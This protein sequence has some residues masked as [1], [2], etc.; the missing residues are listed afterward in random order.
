MPRRVPAPTDQELA[1]AASSLARRAGLDAVAD[2]LASAA[3]PSTWLRV[4][5]GRGSAHS[6]V[7]PDYLEGTFL[8]SRPFY[9][10]VDWWEL[11]R[12]L[13]RVYGRKS[14]PARGIPIRGGGFAHPDERR[15]GAS[16]GAN[17][18]GVLAWGHV[19][20]RLRPPLYLLTLS[21]G[22]GH[23]FAH[24]EGQRH[25]VGDRFDPG[26]CTPILGCSIA[27][28]T[29]GVLVE[30]IEGGKREP[31]H[32]WLTR[33]AAA[34]SPER[35]AAIKRAM[36]AERE[37]TRIINDW[38][39][40]RID[41]T[42]V[43]RQV[44][45]LLP[46]LPTTGEGRRV[47]LLLLDETGGRPSPMPEGLE[48]ASGAPRPAAPP[49]AP[50][51][52]PALR[53]FNKP[54][55]AERAGF[56]VYQTRFPQR[57]DADRQAR[58]VQE[59]H[60]TAELAT[61]RHSHGWGTSYDL[62][63]TPATLALVSPKRNPADRDSAQPGHPLSRHRDRLPGGLAD[64]HQPE[65]F[66][67]AELAAGIAVE[68]EHTDDPALAREIAMDHLAEIPDYYTRLAAMEAGARPLPVSDPGWTLREAVK[69]A[70]LLEDH[71]A[72]PGKRCGD[73]IRKHLLAIEGY[74]EEAAGLGAEGEID[75]AARELALAARAWMRRFLGGEAPEAVGQDVRR[76]RKRL[77]PEL[78]GVRINPRPRC[79]HRN[80]A[81]E[82][83]G[84]P[85]DAPPRDVQRFEARTPRYLEDRAALLGARAGDRVEVAFVSSSWAPYDNDPDKAPKKRRVYV[86][87][88]DPAPSGDYGG[89]TQWKAWAVAEDGRK[90]DGAGM[91]SVRDYNRTA[92]FTRHSDGREDGNP[93][94][95]AWVHLRRLDDPAAGIEIPP[96][97]ALARRAGL[98][99]LGAWFD[100]LAGALV[101]GVEGSI[102]AELDEAPP[103]APVT[104]PAAAPAAPRSPP[105]GQAPAAAPTTPAKR[106]RANLGALAVLRAAQATKART[107]SLPAIDDPQRAWLAA[108]T[109]WAGLRGLDK[110]APE[111]R[112][113]LAPLQQE[114]LR[115]HDQR[116]VEIAELAHLRLTGKALEDRLT[117]FGRT[118]T[119]WRGLI[120]QF[121]TPLDI[122]EAMGRWALS[123]FDQVN[124]GRRPLKALEPAAG[125]GRMIEAWE[126]RNAETTWTAVEP[127]P[128]LADMVRLRWPRL[129]V[130]EG[131]LEGFM[132]AG[133]DRDRFDL[134]VAN[135][136]YSEA[137]GESRE[138]DPEYE[139]W[140]NAAAYFMV[141]CADAL[142]A[143]GVM[144]QITPASL[145]LTD[146]H[147]DLRSELL[148][149][150]H[151]FGAVRPPT[152]LFKGAGASV[153]T[154]ITVWGKRPNRLPQVLPADEGVL[155]GRYFDE[156]GAD[157]GIMGRLVESRRYKGR[158]EVAGAWD[159]AKLLAQPLRVPDRSFTDAPGTFAVPES[160]GVDA[161]DSVGSAA[162]ISDTGPI[163][164]GES[165]GY[166]VSQLQ[167]AVTTDPDRARQIQPE[168]Q[169]DLGEYL[170]SYGNP[171]AIENRR[172]TAAWRAL[173]S[174]V[175][176]K[177]GALAPVV[178][179]RPD[180]PPG[181]Y[182][183]EQNAVAAVLHLA[184]RRGG[185]VTLAQAAEL[186]GRPV[187]VKEVIGDAR[188]YVNGSDDNPRGEPVFWRA[189]EYLTGPIYGKLDWT[190]AALAGRANLGMTR[191]GR[192][193]E[194]VKGKLRRQEAELLGAATLTPIG[195]IDIG[196]RTH[197][198]YPRP[199][200]GIEYDATY[201][202]EWMEQAF[203]V[204]L[205]RAWVEGGALHVEGPGANDAQVQEV[206]AYFNR[207]DSL[208][209]AKGTRRRRQKE[210]G[211]EDR[212]AADRQRDEAFR[213]FVRAHPDAAT[214][215]DRYN[216]A[217]NGYVA[218]TYSDEPIPLAR[219]DVE[220]HAWVK[221]YQW[222]AVRRGAE[223]RGGIVALD[224]G[225]GKTL[226]AILILLL[227]RQRGEARRIMLAVPNTV[228]PNWLSEFAFWAPNVRV[229][230]I[231]FTVTVTRSGEVR[232]TSDSMATVEAKLRAF[233]AGGYDCA[234]VQHSTLA[235]F[236]LDPDNL[237]DFYDEHFAAQREGALSEQKA[238]ADKRKAET[239]A[240]D[241][242]AG[243]VPASKRQATQDRID[244]LLV[245]PWR[246]RLQRRLRAARTDDERRSVQEQIKAWD[247]RLSPTER[248]QASDQERFE[249]W[250]SQRLGTPKIEGI[251]WEQLGVDL[252]VVDELHEY[253]NLYGPATRYGQK[254]KYMGAMGANQV[255]QKCW[256]LWG[257][258]A[259]LRQQHRDTGVL[260][261]TATPLKNSPLEAFNLLAYITDA[262]F[263][264][265]GLLGPEDYI[266]R[267]CKG[268]AE[269]V[270]TISGGFRE[271]MA[272]N[273]FTNLD[274]LRGIFEAWVDVKVAV[275][276]AEYDR[277]VA[278]GVNVRNIVPL[279]VPT[280][281]TT[282]RRVP[283]TD[284]QHM[285]YEAEREKVAGP[286]EQAALELCKKDTAGPGQAVANPL[287]TS[288]P[289]LDE[290]TA[291]PEPDPVDARRADAGTWLLAN[292]GEPDDDD[293]DEG[294]SDGTNKGAIILKAMD[295]MSKAALDP[296]LLRDV[297]GVG[298]PPKFQAVAQEIK[299]RPGC[300][301]IVFC[302]YNEAHEGILATIA[303]RSGIPRRRMISVTGDL[304][305]GER[306]DVA[307]R[308]NG[309]W[310]PAAGA[311]K[312]EP[313][314]DVIIGGKA[315]EQGINLQRRSCAIHHLTLPWEPATVQQRNGRG[316]RQGNWLAEPPDRRPPSMRHLDGAVGVEI[317][318]Y[319][320]ERSF[321]GYKL[322]LISGKRGWMRTLL[323]SADKS[324]NNPGASLQ[325]PCAQLIALAADE[326][327]ARAYCECLQNKAA[328]R[329]LA[330]RRTD[331]AA[332]FGR[333]VEL[334]F[335]QRIEKDRATRKRW[336]QQADGIARALRGLPRDVFER[337]DLIDTAAQVPVFFDAA[338]NKVWVEGLPVCMANK[339]YMVERVQPR[340]RR[341]VY[342]E[343]GKWVSKVATYG[344]AAQWA[345]KMGA[346]CEWSHE[347]D[348]QALA[349]SVQPADVKRI[350]PE[351]A[352][353][354]EQ[355]LLAALSRKRKDTLMPWL[356]GKRGT[357][358]LAPWRQGT[359]EGWIL[360]LPTR[361]GDAERFIQ[362]VRRLR[363]SRRVELK[364]LLAREYDVW[365]GR[366]YPKDLREEV[367]VMSAV[368]RTLG[369][370][371]GGRFGRS[372]QE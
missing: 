8:D 156:P 278:Q 165:L 72:H 194:G 318:Y 27:A 283:M 121:F 22:R 168:L 208:Y 289:D 257:K 232:S 193:V 184:A 285:V 21:D 20:A 322:T 46:D 175:D 11:E 6:P 83:P 174:V 37:I 282:L 337:P 152:D 271:Q 75:A 260:G 206:V 128:D 333:L 93:T 219:V 115:I 230:P 301:H 94:T 59:R 205:A 258:A 62:W 122:C 33:R 269:P 218:R 306:Q 101:A 330:R 19:G 32:A 261:L 43:Q 18:R 298:T 274:E 177:T 255:V 110:L 147:R 372:S 159:G 336:Q 222:A 207:Q 136:P 275:P 227:L 105:A 145:L 109:G 143:R 116:A 211:L 315:I 123:V 328:E 331:A 276:K 35:A 30:P 354:R 180:L 53:R 52:P 24:L 125:I 359:E 57:G 263:R 366:V 34:L 294:D 238:R 117:S 342:R 236:G 48:P 308:F 14:I 89:R 262:A 12:L 326:Q 231:G 146:K 225:L 228:G 292:R 82:L 352:Q 247:K 287:Q 158:M 327:Q 170:G 256:D 191:L 233:A 242:A 185:P 360:L 324:T 176:P 214:I 162:G 270:L 353:A 92:L 61:V 67:A 201:L 50:P 358:E 335:A 40:E 160:E 351:V 299:D 196:I 127:D 155:D 186:L 312:R 153:D 281:T 332:M 319:L 55:T 157:A 212:I 167:E 51:S 251:T 314:L 264:E 71:L 239:L 134:V 166:R 38:R 213:A 9:R 244:K 195:E 265:R 68:Q 361:D 91:L 189:E 65:H 47:A 362:G 150:C 58:L 338:G 172:P 297:A 104:A 163:R 102:A 54:A 370:S 272:V 280:S 290:W 85:D 200:T 224:V 5:P 95:A 151:L 132:V 345:D 45:P 329:V 86:L 13:G 74:A 126:D 235:A 340:Q 41:R 4:K 114:Y 241:L 199:G 307:R 317:L 88:A 368:G 79:P 1:A 3:D 97:A 10:V 268:E 42:T 23:R 49:P 240:A 217:Y 173:L 100:D 25:L 253:K 309:E 249:E 63:A 142:A 16:W 178:S 316:V 250:V 356:T 140:R 304:S 259:W 302:D 349:R 365:F 320:T 84:P 343:L 237:R 139:R 90:R 288:G 31:L 60:P 181:H 119:A 300:S 323:E 96:L 29:A 371:K 284:V 188:V 363:R 267:Y 234:V 133:G 36:N 107:G 182:R 245:Y 293:D 76:V 254:L 243:R 203:G 190:R 77:M 339:T 344:E 149:S 113:L 17:R 226:V 291:W 325:G 192:L 223:R 277:L 7:H 120:S 44:R 311:W 2:L 131:Y 64:A 187:T 66:D 341:I 106:L 286:V 216:R 310:D 355:A 296:S 367:T 164:L 129:H 209:D 179:D 103:A 295:R 87:T 78:D 99:D 202:R 204:E 369:L 279:N 70:I 252:L 313:E 221:P 124:A 138:L 39:D 183:G 197:W 248:E 273:T 348:A 56:E 215:A 28:S 135:P 266:E 26:A 305:P 80:P 118:R 15:V 357:L 108:Y 141:R 198:L 220:R 111:D 69:Q 73:C 246:D 303:A 346:T 350:A 169:G 148:R 144:V 364:E 112:A 210:K 98:D 334:R 229:I 154:V 171:H 81:V 161:P 130:F 321:D 137:R 347:A